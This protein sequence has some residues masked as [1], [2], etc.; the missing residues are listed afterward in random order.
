MLMPLN[1]RKFTIGFFKNL[2][3]KEK[4]ILMSF[5]KGVIL[6]RVVALFELANWFIE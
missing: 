5:P 6:L 2:G 4:I 1:T 3:T